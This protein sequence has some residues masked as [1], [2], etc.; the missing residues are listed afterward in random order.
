MSAASFFAASSDEEEEEQEQ[1]AAAK[2][3]LKEYLALPQI[4]FKSEH[5]AMMWWLEHQEQFPNLE[6]MARQYLGC[7]AIS[8]SLSIASS[9]RSASR[10]RT[11]ASARRRRPSRTS[12]S[13]RSICPELALFKRLNTKNTQCVQKC[14]FKRLKTLRVKTLNNVKRFEKHEKNVKSRI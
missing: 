1:E 6:V 14:V 12:C 11:S 2:D 8:A 7:P 13:R 10:S 5:D 9:P 4:K 3:E